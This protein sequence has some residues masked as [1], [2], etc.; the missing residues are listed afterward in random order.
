MD[1][2]QTVREVLNRFNVEATEDLVAALVEVM[3]EE[4][5]EGWQRGM[6]QANW[7]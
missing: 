6:D 5:M 2:E 1:S 4:N 7:F 3:E